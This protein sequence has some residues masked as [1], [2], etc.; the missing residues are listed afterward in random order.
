[1]QQVSFKV[2][3]RWGRLVYNRIYDNDESIYINWDGRDN[4]GKDLASAVYYYEAKIKFDA[5]DP[6]KQ[7]QT[8]KGWVHLIR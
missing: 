6:G 8:I 7:D 4:Q 1:M 2:Y 3:N 5:I